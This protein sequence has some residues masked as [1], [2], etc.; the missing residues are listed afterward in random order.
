[1][2]GMP[3]LVEFQVTSGSQYSICQ[4]VQLYRYKCLAADE[5]GRGSTPGYVAL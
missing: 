2:G 5:P 3:L 1:M 4:Y